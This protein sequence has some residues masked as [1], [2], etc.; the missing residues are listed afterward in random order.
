MATHKAT[1][2]R[3]D[4]SVS[5]KLTLGETPF[6]IVLTEDKP[7]E[8]KTVF[9]KLLEQLK[10]GEFDFNLSDEKE[11]LYYHICKEYI[12]QLN[13]ELKSTYKEL[14]DNGLLKAVE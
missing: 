11:D 9:N 7:N 5:L 3:K 12:T 4:N 8:V 1:I 14:K 10:Y 6:E 2:E 13:T